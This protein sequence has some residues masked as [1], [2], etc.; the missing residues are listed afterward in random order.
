MTD[1]PAI[2]APADMD[3]FLDHPERDVDLAHYLRQ[4][5]I[6]ERRQVPAHHRSWLRNR[7]FLLQ[8]K[9]WKR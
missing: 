3:F 9:P 5:A 8:L 6:S 7:D 1:H 2:L 4:R